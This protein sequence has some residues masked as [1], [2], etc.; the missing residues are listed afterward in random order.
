MT[1][2]T[3]ADAAP[4]MSLV[5]HHG[6]VCGASSGI[7][8]AAARAMAALGAELT[9]VARREDRLRDLQTELGGE[10]IHVLALDLDD[11]DGA[12]RAIG[13]SLAGKT[14]VTLLINNSGG[15]PGGPLLQAT[16]EDFMKGFGRHVLVSHALVKLLVPAMTEAR[17]GR[18]INIISTSVREPIV[19]L[20]VSNTIR[21]AM[22]SWAKTLSKELPP[23]IT[24]N[25][26]LP[27]F[28]DT[29]RLDSLREAAAKRLG[30]TESQVNDGWLAAVPEKRLGRA[31]EI[32][33]MIAFLAS[34]AASF[35]RGQSIAVDGGRIASI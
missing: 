11:R 27:G 9:L 20:G 24:I 26:V 7:G 21:G 3:L 4:S 13:E 19:N 12:I 25:N 17:Y 32:A 22:A 15:P 31:E 30:V 18:I 35:V 10:G 23:N 2:E 33:A 6:L 8:R 29:E 16:D 28:T 1:R 5:G 14:P 34:P